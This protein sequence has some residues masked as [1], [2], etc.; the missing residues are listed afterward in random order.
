M[1]SSTIR[2]IKIAGV[3]SA[4]PNTKVDNTEYNNVFDEET[5]RKTIESTGVRSTYHS[6]G[7]QT[8][9]DLAYSAAKDLLDKKGV[10]PA[11]IGILLMIILHLLQHLS[12]RNSSGYPKTRW[13]STLI[14]AVRDSYTVCRSEHHC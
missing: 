3:A 5:V 12:S 2:G 7:K 14:W 8:A 9:S 4:V 13:Y 10:D 1:L 6:V 11:G